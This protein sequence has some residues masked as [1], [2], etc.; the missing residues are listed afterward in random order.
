MKRLLISI[1]QKL[2]IMEIQEKLGKDFTIHS[3]DG[4]RKDRQIEI[5]LELLH[6]I[7]LINLEG[8][9]PSNLDKIY[10]HYIHI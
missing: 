1:I 8:Q 5:L 7:K 4:Q 2:I 6:L 9:A 10:I 3:I